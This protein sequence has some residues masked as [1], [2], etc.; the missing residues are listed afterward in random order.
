[1]DTK[2]KLGKERDFLF[3]KKKAGISEIWF[4]PI[5]LNFPK[6]LTEK[7]KAEGIIQRN[8]KGPWDEMEKSKIS[9]V[10]WKTLCIH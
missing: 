3:Y 8:L 7:E 4:L 5:Q 1:M 9:L 10:D 2:V 6:N